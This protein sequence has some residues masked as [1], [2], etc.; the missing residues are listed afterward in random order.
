MELRVGLS[1]KYFN[2]KTVIVVACV[3]AILFSNKI[4]LAE[5]ANLGP[6]SKLR[7][8]GSNTIGEKF[9]P[10]LIKG[11]LQQKQ[12]S[13]LNFDM[14]N[15]KIERHIFARQDSSTHILEIELYA[16][17]SSTGFRDLLSLE[18]DVAMSSRRI[19][20]KEIRQLS[21]IYPSMVTDQ[22]EH[23]IAYDALAIIVNPLN[24]IA[25]LSMQQLAKIFSGEI[26]NWNELGSI[27]EEISLVSRDDNSGTYDTFKSLVLKPFKQK[28]SSSS[29]RIES[30][31]ELVQRVDSH[32][33]AIGFVGI[34]Y[35]SNSKVLAISLQHGGLGVLP[36]KHT[37]GTE[38]YPLSR[39][40]YMYLPM[41][42]KNP[43]AHKFV[44]YVKSNAGQLLAQKSRLISFFPT[45]SKPL[46]KNVL[47]LGKFKN[48]RD[49][50]H[51]L[52]ITFRLQ[53]N[54]LDAKSHRDI[55]R[56]ISFQKQSPYKKI[57]LTGFWDDPENTAKSKQEAQVWIDEL[58]R[59][60][61]IAN[62][63]PW[64]VHGGFL[65]IENNL[66][67]SGKAINRRIEVWVL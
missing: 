56:L 60:L 15:P 58:K 6:V 5:D 34:S 63:S 16:H 51:R 31:A 33:G 27:D 2:L 13:I 66:I 59:Q 55:R 14:L 54:Q 67:A 38:D 25:S 3:Y 32:V 57:V 4:V 49:F 46:Y 53:H 43:M 9:A 45:K 65:P 50:G 44:S 30:S 10:E 37:I 22:V 12:F 47:L 21:K 42:I 64:E 24:P 52:S 20:A 26:K 36:E 39:K 35:T 41:E 7:I 62:I 23:I 48:L 19:K 40:L 61:A 28:L 17:G 18:T 29:S 8:H 11:F 1:L